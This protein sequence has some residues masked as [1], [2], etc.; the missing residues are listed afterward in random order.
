MVKYVEMKYYAKIEFNL[1]QICKLDYKLILETLILFALAVQ[2]KLSNIGRIVGDK[3]SKC[4]AE[5]D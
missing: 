3:I 5:L 4:I 1:K 2:W